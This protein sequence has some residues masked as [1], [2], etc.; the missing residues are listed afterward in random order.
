[1][2]ALIAAVQVHTSLRRLLA[3]DLEHFLGRRLNPEIAFDAEALDGCGTEAVSRVAGALRG[4]GLRVSFHGPFV[5]L[6][7]GSSDPAVRAVAARRFE[8]I[9]ALV[10]LFRPVTLVAHAGYDWRRH[11]YFRPVWMEHSVRFWSQLA[12]RLAPFGCRLVLENVFERGPEEMA[13]ILA[14]LAAD[15]VGLCLD[16]GHAAAFGEEPPAG[17]VERLGRF[18]GELHLHDNGGRR[19]E[20]LPVGRGRIEFGPLLARLWA[21]HPEPPLMTLE[22]HRRGDLEESLAGLARVL[23]RPL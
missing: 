4:A 8:Q 13:E 21:M 10:P 3:G 7:V 14:R 20:H 22:I 12:A 6:A 23:P 18:V 15:G 9:L 16:V 17:W 2:E 19:D 11:E 5:D 1:M